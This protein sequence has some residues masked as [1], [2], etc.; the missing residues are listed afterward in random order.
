M[1]NFAE[2]EIIEYIKRRGGYVDETDLNTHFIPNESEIYFRLHNLVKSIA[3]QGKL[4]KTSEGY[5]LKK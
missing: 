5:E 1:I 4:Q 3:A 2:S